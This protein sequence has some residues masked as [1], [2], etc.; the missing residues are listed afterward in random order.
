MG[1][2]EGWVEGGYPTI[3]VG[4]GWVNDGLMMGSHPPRVD[5]WF[6]FG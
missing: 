4:S 6:F 5:D 2:G 1:E 3:Q